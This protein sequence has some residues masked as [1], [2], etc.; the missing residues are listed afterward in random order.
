MK[1]KLILGFVLCIA[2]VSSYFYIKTSTYSDGKQK[3]SSEHPTSKPVAQE[4]VAQQPVYSFDKKDV[5]EVKSTSIIEQTTSTADFSSIVKNMKSLAL[6]SPNIVLGTISEVTYT[7]RN[8]IP[9]THYV[10]SIDKSIKGSLTSGSKINVIESNGYVRLSTFIQ[11]FGDDHHKNITD[12]E[13]ENTLILQSIDN[14]PLSKNEE[15]VV[16]FLAE[17]ES[18][19]DYIG[20]YRVMGNY[21][22]KYVYDTKIGKFVRHVES[23]TK[24]DPEQDFITDPSDLRRKLNL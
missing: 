6:E 14:A 1:R 9:L 10:L 4:P 15:K 12:Q 17:Q 18:T 2:M 24:A 20:S 8:A 16:L 11:V 7:D 5:V 23:R 3:L 19:G 13:R 22:G 21:H